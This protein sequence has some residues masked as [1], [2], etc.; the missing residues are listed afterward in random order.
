MS[1]CSACALAGHHR[2][3]RR[4]CPL[5]QMGQQIFIVKYNI[6][7]LVSLKVNYQK[8]RFFKRKRTKPKTL[9]RLPWVLHNGVIVKPVDGT[10]SDIS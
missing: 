7:F 1:N 2:K 8:K 10:P 4:K 5:Y 6:G 3:N 9:V